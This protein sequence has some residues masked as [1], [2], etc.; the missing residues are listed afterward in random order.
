MK[1]IETRYAGHRFRSRLEARWAVF[2][3]VIGVDWQYEPEGFETFA[4]PYLPD[5][6]IPEFDKYIEIK[7]DGPL[8][9]HD[10]TRMVA[11]GVDCLAAG[12]D[13]LLLTGL[14][15]PAAFVPCKKWIDL[16]YDEGNISHPSLGII[17]NEP[18]CEHLD[19]DLGLV[20]GWVPSRWMP[21]PN[22][23]EALVRARS[24]RFEHGERG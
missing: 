8:S 11:F 18:L 22:V 19:W 10:R 16:P 15:K 6:Y 24:A 9:E 17:N 20:Q 3:D 23:R 14:P 2:W 7:P 12:H 5:F 21:A 4:G 1:A 13:Y